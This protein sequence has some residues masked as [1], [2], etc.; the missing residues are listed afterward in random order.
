MVVSSVTVAYEIGV[1]QV[2]ALAPF[3][4]NTWPVVPAATNAVAPAP[5]W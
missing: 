2:G 4:V 5:D 1:D 3:E